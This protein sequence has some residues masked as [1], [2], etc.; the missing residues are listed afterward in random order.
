MTMLDRNLVLN[1]YDFVLF[2]LYQQYPAYRE[3]YKNLRKSHPDRLMILDNSAYEFF[4]KGETLQPE[5]FANAIIDLNPDFYILPDKLMDCRATIDMVEE[6]LDIYDNVITYDTTSKPLAVAQGNSKS[7]LVECLL[8]YYAMDIK[9][10]A[11]PFHNSFYQDYS[12]ELL[13][14]SWRLRYGRITKD[15]RYALGRIQFVRDIEALLDQF[16]HVHLLGS[17]NPAEKRYYD[18]YVIKTMDTGYPVKLA[19]T[20]VEL[21]KENSKPDIIIDDFMT[22]ELTDKQKMLIDVNINHFKSF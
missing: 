16:K 4:V 7:E 13:Q 22:T 12:R 11:L 3:Y 6:F 18:Q 1:D 9:N 10:I 21:G 14:D 15:D 5:L 19:I 17:H 2:H 20:G 8:R